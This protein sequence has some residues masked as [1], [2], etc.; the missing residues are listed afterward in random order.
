MRLPPENETKLIGRAEGPLGRRAF[1]TYTHPACNLRKGGKMKRIAAAACLAALHGAA[2]A[3][4]MKPV[5]AYATAAKV[6]D[7]CLAFAAEKKIEVSIAVHDEA[8]RLMTFAKM[9][10]ASTAVSD[11]AIWKSR[12][13]ATFRAPSANTAQWNIPTAPGIATA[14]GG[15][16]MFTTDGQPLGAIGVSGA[17]TEDDIACAEA[18]IRGAGLR[19]SR[20]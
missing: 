8:G 18:G 20:P 17:Q 14:G 6:R 5:L 3:Q 11:L 1:N 16:P 9:D 10:G 13:A 15:V 2:P 7:G 19:S 12:S 4:T